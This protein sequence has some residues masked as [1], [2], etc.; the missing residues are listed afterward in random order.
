MPSSSRSVTEEEW[1]EATVTSEVA[2]TTTTT[3]GR[4][5]SVAAPPSIISGFSK[6]TA[7]TAS[8]SSELAMVVSTKSKD[9]VE[10][11]KELD[12]YFLKAADAGGPLSLLLEVPTCTFPDL[13]SQPGNLDLPFLNLR[14]VICTT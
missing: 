6:D 8:T 12:D 14:R 9:L 5:A 3:V 1:D 4:D 10:I 11:I 2:V 13:K 7:A